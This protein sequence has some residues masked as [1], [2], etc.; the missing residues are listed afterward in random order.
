M[1]F[2]MV[3]SYPDH[4]PKAHCIDATVPD[5]TLRCKICGSKWD[6]RICT[7]C[8]YV[9]CCESH[10]GHAHDHALRFGHPVI[11]EVARDGKGR[12]FLWCYACE[13]YLESDGTPSC[14]PQY[15]VL[16]KKDNK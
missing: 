11:M 2:I 15:P 12:G 13:D 14:A 9:G 4:D 7:E 8:G 10:E 3:N 5:G 6:L 16:P 1:A